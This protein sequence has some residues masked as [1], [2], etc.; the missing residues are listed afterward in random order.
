[1]VGYEYGLYRILAAA[2]VS[3]ERQCLPWFSDLAGAMP[4]E[5]EGMHTMLPVSAN[6]RKGDQHSF[7]EWQTQSL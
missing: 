2:L 4:A 3:V 6:H 5:V 7:R 1:M